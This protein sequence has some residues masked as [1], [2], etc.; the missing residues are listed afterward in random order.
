MLGT[1]IT[2]SALVCATT[3]ELIKY[4]ERR[5]NIASFLINIVNPHKHD[6]T[7]T[8]DIFKN[9]ALSKQRHPEYRPRLFGY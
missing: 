3:P 5:L 6:V 9:T 8:R 2:E 7:W 4:P 1:V